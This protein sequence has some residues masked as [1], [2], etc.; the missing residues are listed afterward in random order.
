VRFHR[1]GSQA[2]VEIVDLRFPHVRPDRPAAFTY[3][4]RFD[5]NGKVLS[6]GWAE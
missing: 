6:Q 5:A 2:I 4:V 3:E 1:E